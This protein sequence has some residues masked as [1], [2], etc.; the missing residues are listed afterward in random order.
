[1]NQANKMRFLAKHAYNMAKE[2]IAL[3]KAPAPEPKKKKKKKPS[4]LV[5]SEIE[6]VVYLS[7]DGKTK[8]KWSL[9]PSNHVHWT[10]EKEKFK[11]S[12]TIILAKDENIFKYMKNFLEKKTYEYNSK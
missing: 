5:L 6:S 9:L 2:T 1:M 12:D 4:N 8:I 3:Y 7:R 10:L 11:T